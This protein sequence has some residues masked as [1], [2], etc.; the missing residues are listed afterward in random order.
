MTDAIPLAERYF[1]LSNDSRLDE[2]ETLLT[3]STTYSSQNTGVYLGASAIMEMQ[4]AFHGR[5]EALHWEIHA[6]KETRPGV[7]WF[8]FTFN[9]R[10]KDGEMI[11]LQGEEYVI[12]YN[13]KIQ[14][15]EVR[16]KAP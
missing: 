9:G 6:F 15:V 13:G 7:V 1:Q 12:V 16:N 2:I 11:T 3:D 10:T 4:R 8:D 14:H 5:F